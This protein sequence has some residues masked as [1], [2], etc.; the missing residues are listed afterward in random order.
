VAHV[1]VEINVAL[2]DCKGMTENG[3]RT[4][5]MTWRYTASAGDN[6]NYYPNDVRAAIMAAAANA[7][8]NL[9]PDFDPEAA[10]RAM[11]AERVARRG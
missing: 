3:K 7:V 10:R 4:A 1:E 6:P 8:T 5:G 9:A 2:S 11:E